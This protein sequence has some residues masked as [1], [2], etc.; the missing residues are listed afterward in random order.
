[1][2]Q[3]PSA[4]VADLE[5]RMALRLNDAEADLARAFARLFWSRTPEEDLTPRQVEDD[6]GA[7]IHLWRR[8]RD[9]THDGMLIQVMNPVHARD[10]WQSRRTVVQIMA[11]DM[12]FCVDSVLIA[13]S[14]DGLI[15][16][17]LSN[18]VFTVTRDANGR[19]TAIG[20]RSED[21]DR[22]L[23]I[24]AE[25]DRVPDSELPRIRERLQ[26]TSNDLLA[27]ISDFSA[28]KL[29][30]GELI[31]E[32]RDSPPAAVSANEMA[33]GI[34][35]LDWLA[36]NNFTFLGYREF[37]YVDGVLRQSGESLGALRN[38][39]PATERAL[40]KQPES[41]REF[42]LRPSL[43]SFSK[44]GT[45][46][47]VHRPAYP[48]YVGIKRFNDQGEV[49]GERGFLGLYT[50]PVYMEHPSRIP[51]VRRKVA[52]VIER[53]NLDPAGFD[54]KVLAQVLATYPRDELFQISE[55]ELFA[56]AMAITYIH[57]R[58]RLRVFSRLEPYG[59]FVNCLVYVP[60]DLFN[61]S[62]RLQVQQYLM[63][64]FGADDCEF[65]V[66]MSESILVRL[67]FIMRIRHGSQP[68]VD[69][70]ELEARI[71][72]ITGDWVS[73]FHEALLQ[74]FGETQGRQLA[75]RYADAF[76]AGYREV[77]SARDA[78]DDV[79]CIQQ[80][81]ADRPLLTRFYRHLE[82]AAD[83][84]QL[85]VF[86][87]GEPLAL[88]QIVPHLENMGLHVL[89]EDVSRIERSTDDGELPPVALQA[90]TLSFP[91]PLDPGEASDRFEDAFVR[92]CDGRS[93]DDGFNGLVLGAGLDWRQVAVL[94]S[95]ARY[96]KQIRFGFSQEFIA[97][98][99]GRHP[100]I[101]TAIV[102]LF[103]KRFDAPQPDEQ[104]VAAAV[105]SIHGQLDGVQ[106]LNEDRI[107]RRFVE[108]MLATLRSNYRQRTPAGEPK[109]Y[110]ALKFAPQQ[111]SAMPEP[112]PQREIFVCAPYFEGVHLRSGAIARG[113]LRWSDRLE[114]FRTEVLGLVKAQ[115]VKNAVIVPTGA[116]G[117][118]VLKPGRGTG[119]AP[120]VVHCYREFISG[121]L[122]LTDN[123]VAGEIEAPPEV[124]RYDADDPYLVV[125][126][127][128]GTATFSDHANAVAESYGFWLGDAFASGG[129]NGY[130]HKA[131]GITARGGWVS[132]Q[133][134]FAE[135]GID[136]QREPVTVLGIG[137]MS[138]DVFGNGLL[139]S[140]AVKLVGAFNH[141]H[142]FIDPDPDPERSYAERQ[143]LFALPR[144]SWD[145]YDAALI[146][147]GGGVFS[148]QAKAITLSPEIRRTF[149]IDATELAPDEL[150]S[151]LLRSPVQL[152]WNGG[153]G[154]YV[155]ASQ[156]TH[157]SVGD[158]TNDHLRVDAAELRCTAF[159]EG[160][161]LGLTQLARIE[162][163]LRGGAVNTDFIDNSAGVDCSDHEVNIK[164]ALNEMVA[165][166]DLTRKQRNQL[167]ESMTDAVA[168]LVLANNAR[169]A[170]CLSLA[171]RHGQ[172]RQSEYQRFIQRMETDHTLNRQLEFL[173]SDDALLERFGQGQGLTR[174][175]LAVLLAYAKTFIK[176]RLVTSRIHE[177]PSIA[178]EVLTPFPA[179]LVA[180]HEAV[181]LDH[182]LAREIIST[183]LANQIVD[184]L[185]ITFVTHLL[186]FVGGTVEE[187]ARAAYVALA[188]FEIPQWYAQIEALDCDE[189]I[190]LDMLVDI[191]RLGRRSAR[192]ILRHRRDAGD[193]AGLIDGFRP[194]VRELILQRE[195]FQGPAAVERWQERCTALEAGQV[196]AELARRSANAAGLTVALPIID[197]ADRVNGDVAAVAHCYAQIGQRLRLGWL[198]EQL[199]AL[200]AN[201][202]WQAMERDS[203][204]DDVITQ[205]CSLAA[206]VYGS[207]Q[208]VDHWLAEQQTFCDNWQRVVDDIAHTGQLD[209][210]MYAMACRKLI[211][212]CRNL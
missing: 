28:M 32:L 98:T 120:D 209:F 94:R 33:E 163:G 68:R 126:A 11:K 12:P 72:E 18:V 95:Y 212:L 9:R 116:K 170:Q 111:I 25:I 202:H 55:D 118:F 206:L 49:V 36:T 113:G 142:I 171:E 143:R 207:G 185:G 50:S 59:M 137:D 109:P 71:I 158:R 108:L 199:A 141:L 52:S 191:M 153:I 115:I 57:E 56:T 67:Q 104:A 61:T 86:R 17:H 172:H 5:K 38:R 133:R 132:V 174:P 103:E 157:D 156:E 146:S 97:S 1:M 182:R 210:S 173:P 203:L 63:D 37:E 107:L 8:F 79:A 65:D 99:L 193:L 39:R 93:E 19:L 20:P 106:L 184:L 90:F 30:L 24:H 159:G 102:G 53:S 140:R 127:D 161:N 62:S 66:F 4:Y 74:A 168:E 46:S 189:N 45:K 181:L 7:T 82:D 135:R 134:H 10:G 121:L 164:I 31:D 200:P 155:K 2:N 147:T 14:H 15:T 194:R 124:T 60:R 48:D 125:A 129:S 54:G 47:R 76:P 198:S 187:I 183:Q 101:A 150:I 58:R 131:M 186:E 41:T 112:R 69:D 77:A 83:R 204:L 114:D 84:L 136:V 176:S 91:G 160:G 70:R 165:R 149:D 167:L 105:A 197:A 188:S 196:D 29:R 192:W 96:M 34:A 208:D 27:V 180:R 100:Q 16:H 3:S 130:D 175:E 154:T 73:E 169:Q 21:G 81:S 117:G 190:K 144:S 110:L 43:L 35:F 162:F 138:G 88:S 6:A 205:Q 178:R 148:R 177:D 26:Q 89:G 85:K 42:L 22:E 122:D 40:A 80:L 119:E 51:V 211:D 123:I 75:R 44:S 195:Q 64:V 78:V 166:E 128:K 92:I 87:L 145:G 139:L 179:A 151:A 152:I 23:V 13:L 201:S